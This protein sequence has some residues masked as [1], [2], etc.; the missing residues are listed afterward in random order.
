MYT[1]SVRTIES[2]L[3]K[4]VRFRIRSTHCPPVMSTSVNSP[5]ANGVQMMP[6]AASAQR[7]TRW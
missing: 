3:A 2:E 6:C 7:G 4:P 1:T 5:S